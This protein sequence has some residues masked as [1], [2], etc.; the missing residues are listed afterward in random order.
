MVVTPKRG[1]PPGPTGA[2]REI[3]LK[4]A[5]SAPEATL[6]DSLALPNEHRAT[7]I[8]RVLKAYADLQL[9]FKADV[10]A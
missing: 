7:T 5:L 6:L 3:V 4:I 1:R 9:L 8:R 2:R 10:S